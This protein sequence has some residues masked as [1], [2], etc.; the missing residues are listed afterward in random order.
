MVKVKTENNSDLNNNN[1]QDSS[2][3]GKGS[4]SSMIFALVSLVAVVAVYF[5][6]EGLN[7][8]IALFKA[9]QTPK[10]ISKRASDLL[11]GVNS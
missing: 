6:V 4:Y 3:Q 7:Q 11:S 2:S 5:K 9:S 1:S 8:E 10:D